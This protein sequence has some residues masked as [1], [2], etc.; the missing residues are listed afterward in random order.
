MILFFGGFSF[1][2][3][4]PRAVADVEDVNFI[5]AYGKKDSVFVLTATVENLADFRV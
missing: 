5:F 3:R 4:Q 2:Q 1:A